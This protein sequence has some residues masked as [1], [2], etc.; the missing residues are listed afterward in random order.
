M[1]HDRQSN[2]I[3]SEWISVHDPGIGTRTDILKQYN[4]GE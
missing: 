4:G 3:E 2:V 1:N